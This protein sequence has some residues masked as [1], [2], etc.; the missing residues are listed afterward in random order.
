MK[1]LVIFG[2][3]DLAQ[4]AH[5]YFGKEQ[6]REIAAFTLDREYV[7]QESFCSLPVVAFENIEERFPPADYDMFVAL[8]YTQMNRLRERK[9]Q[10]ARAKGYS[11]STF[12]SPHAYAPE[13]VS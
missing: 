7:T 6:G 4:L 8:S 10:E 11:L 3:K 9:C 2:S 5:Y 13:N 1:K 12:V